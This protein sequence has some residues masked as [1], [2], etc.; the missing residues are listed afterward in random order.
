MK[1]YADYTKDDLMRLLESLTP[2]GSEYYEEPE[3]C[4]ER[5]R[6]HQRSIKRQMVKRKEAERQRDQLLAVAESN[7]KIL[8]SLYDTPTESGVFS[9][10]EYQVL[11]QAIADT[12]SAIAAAKGETL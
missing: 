1:R 8:K 12:E 5:I 4:A 3:T 11:E 2:G 7:L 10:I 6:D 9:G